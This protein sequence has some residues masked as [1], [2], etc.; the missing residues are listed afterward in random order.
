MFLLFFFICNTFSLSFILFIYLLCLFF[1]FIFLLLFLTPHFSQEMP[2]YDTFIFFTVSVQCQ[3]VSQ[4]FNISTS[5]VVYLLIFLRYWSLTMRYLY[6]RYFKFQSYLS[7]TSSNQFI[8]KILL[9][10]S[11]NLKSTISPLSYYF[12][13]IIRWMKKIIYVV[14]HRYRCSLL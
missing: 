8:T 14:I 10:T 11:M 1:L 5:F 3:K 2:F 12:T 7:V 6:L 4:M 9:S 13:K